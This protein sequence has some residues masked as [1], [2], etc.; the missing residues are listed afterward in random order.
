[1]LFVPGSVPKITPCQLFDLE[2]TRRTVLSLTPEKAAAL[3]VKLRRENQLLRNA[4][5]E[6]SNDNHSAPGIS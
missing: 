6:I 1:M 4:L 5:H 2:L 3:A